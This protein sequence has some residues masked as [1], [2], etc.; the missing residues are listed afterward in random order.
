MPSSQDF[1]DRLGEI[2]GKLTDVNNKLQK[3]E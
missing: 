3:V 1:L 2:S